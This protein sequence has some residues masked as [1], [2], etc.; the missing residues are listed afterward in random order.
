MKIKLFILTI[1]IFLWSCTKN[2]NNESQSFVEKIGSF[3]GSNKEPIVYYNYKDY[4]NWYKYNSNSL[5]DTILDGETYCSINYVPAEMDAIVGASQSNDFSKENIL[6]IYNNKKDN[7]FIYLKF[8]QNNLNK[9]N[10][11]DSLNN[12]AK[13]VSSS[14]FIIKNTN[15]TLK[16]IFSDIYPTNM[17]NRPCEVVIF[18]PKDSTINSLNMNILTKYSKSHLS[19]N[20]DNITLKNLPKLKL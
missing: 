8:W 17:L 2:G 15:D 13:Q 20:I 3:L 6:K 4:I 12:Y 5:S 1:L 10:Q 19:L 18:I 9:V 7:Y 11:I 14:A 16:N